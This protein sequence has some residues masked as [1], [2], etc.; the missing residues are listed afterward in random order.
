[1]TRSE[2]EIS[3]LIHALETVSPLIYLNSSQKKNLIEA[4]FF[5]EITKKETIYSGAVNN[6]RSG[7]NATF[8]LLKGFVHFY[9]NNLCHIDSFKNPYFFGHDGPIFG[10]RN[11]TVITEGALIAVI[12]PKDFL[13]IIVP[14]SKFSIH[15]SRTIIN[16]EKTLNNLNHF[17][18][19][20]LGSASKGTIDLKKLIMLY[21]KID[22][23]LH[24]KALNPNEID[25]SAWLY[26]LNRL[27]QNIFNTYVYI[28]MISP[29][30][31]QSFHKNVANQLIPKVKTNSRLRDVYTYLDGKGVI[32]VRDQE[33]DILDFVSNLCIHIIESGKLRRLL[34]VPNK[35]TILHENLNDFEKCFEYVNSILPNPISLE[36]K[37]SLNKWF[38][39]N[40]ARKMIDLIL[41]HDD[42]Y[43][44]IPKENICNNDPIELMIQDV[45]K[46]TKELLKISNSIDEIDDLIVDIIQGSKR[47]LLGCISPY[48]YKNREEIYD[49]AERN[50]IKTITKEFLNESDRLLALSYYYF[51]S[52]PDKKI[53]QQ[54]MDIEH[55]IIILEDQYSTGVSF[56]LINPNKLDSNF[57]DPN[58]KFNKVSD[59]HLILHVGYTFG[60][61]SS[62]LIKPLIMLFGS[63]ARSFNVIGK[64]G[65][66]GGNRT[67]IMVASKIFYDKTNDIANLNTGG[68][69]IEELKAQAKTN[70]HFGPMLTVAGT[71]LQNYDL[72]LFYKNVMGCVGLEME[73]YF[74]A[75]ELEKAK[76][77]GLLGD[78]FV[79][80]Y[81]YYIS[82]LP[83]DSTQNLS[84]E[85]GNVSWD[86]GVCTM[87]A[88]Q[89]F[90]FNQIFS[91]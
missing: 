67:E 74:F 30:Y 19:F 79:S 24:T 46:M 11:V 80:R 14:S 28:L 62:L 52:F 55:G 50:G 21:K 9:D 25:I 69:D 49:Y 45:W 83:L 16:K 88:I 36:D 63:K 41:H 35:V 60:A 61:Q 47:T 51:K 71:I 78:N 86:E 59:N 6:L 76:K 65:G 4:I 56:M 81:F 87:N 42:Y 38:G 85:E 3:L 23:C 10:K 84:K 26:S 22:S 66:L 57:I 53:E 44:S 2:E 12:P 1:M 18:K 70:V 75:E 34:N 17:K 15:L 91:Q 39:D 40:F 77:I 48:L 43:I 20:V 37:I 58:I 29:S 64:A 90:L 32:V 27:P 33:T 8:I 7:D 5:L 72:L 31:M 82:D 73:G 68:L 13:N 89:R 54:Q